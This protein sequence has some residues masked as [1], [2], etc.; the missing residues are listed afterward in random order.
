MNYY[1]ETSL[2]WLD[3]NYDTANLIR[4]IETAAGLIG[5]T[6]QTMKNRIR[7]GTA[8]SSQTEKDR[9]HSFSGRLM[10]QNIIAHR[11]IGIARFDMPGIADYVAE[12]V[13]KRLQVET[14]MT[15]SKMNGKSVYFWHENKQ[16]AFDA[17]T[18]ADNA[19]FSIPVG[20]DVLN[21]STRI[22][23]RCEPDV[24][25]ALMTTEAA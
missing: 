18:N 10:V 16:R 4:G 22:Y 7:H 11:L 24:V 19:T 1:T 13:I 14:I 5:V 15:V 20:Q 6:P 21:L 9:H 3:H 8:F 17:I 23:V 12:N 2:E 25:A